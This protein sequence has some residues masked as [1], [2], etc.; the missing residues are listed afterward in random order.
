MEKMQSQ[1]PRRSITPRPA[2]RTWANSCVWKEEAQA[3]V[4]SSSRW[5][6]ERPM[7]A[8]GHMSRQ[9]LHVCTVQSGVYGC[10]SLV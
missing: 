4:A 6:A 5:K 1:R 3:A 9:L 8:P 7:K 2:I 10:V